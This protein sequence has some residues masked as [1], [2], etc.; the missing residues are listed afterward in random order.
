MRG[1]S[2]LLITEHAST[3]DAEGK[4]YATRIAESADRMDT[5]IAGLLAFGHLGYKEVACVRLHLEDVVQR[6]A[7]QFSAKLQSRNAE[8]R[9]DAPMPDLR[10]NAELLN[11]VLVNL[12]DNALKF[13]APDRPPRI[14]I[15]A[16]KRENVVRLW[17]G[18]NGIG[19]APPY[20]ERV[21]GIFQ[22]LP[23]SEDSSGT[24]I[25]LALVKA[26]VER[27]AGRV[28]VESQHGEGSRFWIELPAGD[29]ASPES[30]TTCRG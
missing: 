19:I 30:I 26:A 24:G 14:R 27:M 16:E 15:W 5:L 7:R 29:L 9:I 2:S 8:L 6:A 23:S 25:G 18:D 12:L 28:G 21:F 1:F 22:R 13:A 3:L 17:V 10:G 20:H 4:E 11:D